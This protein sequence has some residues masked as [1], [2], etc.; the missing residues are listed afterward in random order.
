MQAALYGVNHVIGHLASTEL[1]EGPLPGISSD[2]WSQAGTQ[3][4]WR[5]Q[6]RD[7]QSWS[8]KVP[9]TMPQAGLR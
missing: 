5:S 7:R 3:T 9:W 2:W 8:W 6:Y 1:A 4:S